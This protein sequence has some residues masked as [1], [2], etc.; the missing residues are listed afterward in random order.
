VVVLGENEWQA[1]DKAGTDGEGYDVASLDLTGRQEELLKAV[2]ATGTPTVLVLVNG[3]PLS[4]RW[5]AEHVPAI[6]EAW[7]PGE[8]GGEAVADVLFGDAEPFGRLSITVP[9]H[10][11][12]LPAAYDYKPS[13]A[14]WLKEGW[15]RPYADMSPLPLWPFGHG[16]A[17]TAFEYSNLR[18]APAKARPGETV[19]VAVDVQ[20]A[21][22]RPGSEVVQL[23]VHDPIAS[24]VVPVQ[25]L[26]GFQRVW[27]QPGERRTVEL[28]L[29]ADDLAL[30]D[31]DLRRVVEPG[32]FEVRV[33]RSSGDIRLTGR[34]EVLP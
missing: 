22:A 15:G 19:R 32:Q 24:V 25:R 1:K 5:A 28:G 17:Y 8:R 2:Q 21:G 30:L 3:R 33:G 20:N 27:V 16:L 23:Y 13:K 34:F 6:V 31:A 11:G 18:I 26:R 9:R 14:Y 10:V 29:G 12:Q 4:V 7:L